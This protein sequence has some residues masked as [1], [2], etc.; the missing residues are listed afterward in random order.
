MDTECPGRAPHSVRAAS[1]RRARSDAPSH[2]CELSELGEGRLHPEGMFENS[3]AF[4]RWVGTRTRIS[5]EGT[6]DDR[7]LSRPSGTRPDLA[8][9][10]ALKR[11]AIL[12][13]PSGTGART[14]LPYPLHC[15]TRSCSQ[16]ASKY[17]GVECREAYGLRG[18]CSRFWTVIGRRIAPASWTH[19]IRFAQFGCG[20][21]ALRPFKPSRP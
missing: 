9:N 16:A 18:A 11:W 12:N 8:I 3:P 2:K 5:P 6:A 21:A 1:P 17:R 20:F 15:N 7:R 19:S 10:P 14:R 4:Q 13:R